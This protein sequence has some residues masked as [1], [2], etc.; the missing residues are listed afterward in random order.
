M[1]QQDLA[2]LR[3]ENGGGSALYHLTQ[4]FAMYGRAKLDVLQQRLVHAA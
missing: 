2:L 3:Q 4:A 1:E